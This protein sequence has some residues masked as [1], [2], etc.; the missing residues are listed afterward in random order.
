MSNGQSESNI[1][2]SIPDRD[3]AVLR[4]KDSKL[5]KLVPVRLP[6]DKWDQFRKETDEPGKGSTF[7]FTLPLSSTRN[8]RKKRA[9]W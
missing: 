5:Y 7:W 3:K 1:K 2:E 4:P 6:V 8:S 9:G